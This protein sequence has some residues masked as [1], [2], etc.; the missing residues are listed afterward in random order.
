MSAIGTEGGIEAI[1]AIAVSLVDSESVQ[2]QAF[3]ALKTLA[4]HDCTS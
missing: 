2:E 4:Q 1:L 3:F